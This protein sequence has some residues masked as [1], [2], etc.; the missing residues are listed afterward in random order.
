MKNW[1]A[2]GLVSFVVGVEELVMVPEWLHL[3]H[4]GVLTA[5]WDGLGMELQEL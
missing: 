3:Q 2:T 1:I 5:E 4:L